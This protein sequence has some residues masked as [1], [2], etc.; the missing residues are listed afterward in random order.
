MHNVLKRTLQN[1]IPPYYFKILLS[2]FVTC[3]SVLKICSVIENPTYE[4]K[5]INGNIITNTHPSYN[6]SLTSSLF[7]LLKIHALID[8]INE[9]LQY[10][11]NSKSAV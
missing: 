1:V 5:V 3:T 9:Y 2:P 11:K 4:N 8:P 10:N 6:N 7:S